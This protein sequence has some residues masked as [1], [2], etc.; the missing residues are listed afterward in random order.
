MYYVTFDMFCLSEI[1]TVQFPLALYN[2]TCMVILIER[3]G[4]L[5][6]YTFFKNNSQMQALVAQERLVQS[7]ALSPKV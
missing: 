6:Q 1:Q 4:N 5:Y 7:Q 3:R 2:S